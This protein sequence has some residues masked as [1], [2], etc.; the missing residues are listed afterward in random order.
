MQKVNPIVIYVLLFIVVYMALF[1]VASRPAV[2]TA[3][4][5]LLKTSGMPAVK[6]FLPKLY[7]DPK[8]GEVQEGLGVHVG[9]GDKKQIEAAIAEAKR[10]R[11]ANINAQMHRT[12]FVVEYFTLPLIFLIALILITPIPWRSRLIALVSGIVL[13]L[14]FYIIK[15]VLAMLFQASAPD[16][17]IYKLS[18]FWYNFLERAIV[19]FQVGFSML[20]AVLIWLLTAFRKSNW[21]QLLEKFM[22]GERVKS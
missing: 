3:A 19:S 4:A 21:R 18:P 10:K 17:Q 15:M 1:F 11:Q 12:S 13:F 2:K 5:N 16:I 20:V 7:L 14:L 22:G 9:F 6:T 8:V